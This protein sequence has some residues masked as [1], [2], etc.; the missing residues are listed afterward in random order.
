MGSP[1]S[2]PV[3]TTKGMNIPGRKGS[4]GSMVLDSPAMG[5]IGTGWGGLAPERSTVSSSVGSVNMMGS[6]SESNESDED[7][8]M[9]GDVSDSEL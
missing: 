6:D 8:S 1:G 5:G 2:S 4:V 9:G 7:A 3:M